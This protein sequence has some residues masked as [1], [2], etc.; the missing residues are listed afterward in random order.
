MAKRKAAGEAPGEAAG[1]KARRKEQQQPKRQPAQPAEPAEEE[2]PLTHGAAVATQAG[3]GFKNKE[4]VLL[5]GSRGI[6]YR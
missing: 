1:G 4:K 3:G 6:T 5:L 2:A